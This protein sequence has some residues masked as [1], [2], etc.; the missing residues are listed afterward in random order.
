MLLAVLVISIDNYTTFQYIGFVKC[1]VSAELVQ[2]CSQPHNLKRVSTLFWT[3]SERQPEIY[4][5][6]R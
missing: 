2:T 4:C 6:L 3:R 1:I 5:L